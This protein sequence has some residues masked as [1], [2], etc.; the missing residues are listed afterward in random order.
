MESVNE[1]QTEAELDSL[2][3]SVVRGHPFGRKEWQQSTAK[4]WGLE[5]TLR[6]LGRLRKQ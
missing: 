3:T 2:R 4:R 6:L 5:F 1:V